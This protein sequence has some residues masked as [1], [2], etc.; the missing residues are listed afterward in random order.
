MS[1]KILQ[2]PRPK[3]PPRK[4]IALIQCGKCD[5]VEYR[6]YSSDDGEQ[7]AIECSDCGAVYDLL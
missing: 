4:S 3:S 1:A 7:L 6:C 2:F 5:G